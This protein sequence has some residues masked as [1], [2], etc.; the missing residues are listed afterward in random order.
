LGLCK[1]KLRV[2]IRA[3][4]GIGRE[5]RAGMAQ[6]G[7]RSRRNG[8]TARLRIMMM[9]VVLL[10]L[11]GCA[12]VYRNHGYVPSDVELELIEVGLDTRDTVAATIGRP[13]AAGLL[14]DVG[15]YYVQSRWKHYG[16]LPPK[17]EDRQILA[18]TFTEEG[19]VENI[20]RFGL[21]QGRVVALSRR[22]TDTNIKGLS[23]LQQLFGSIGRLRADQLIGE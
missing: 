20:E 23:V 3:V 1:G 22:V 7:D 4:C 15:W 19:T 11:A 5:A 10:A 14:N 16:A 6:L 9:G 13:S 12:A 17:E 18:I 21:E 2:V 8:A